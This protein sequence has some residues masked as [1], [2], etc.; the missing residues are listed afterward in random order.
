[1]PKNLWLLLG[2]GALFFYFREKVKEQGSL[3]GK[4]GPWKIN[5]NQVVDSVMPWI[6]VHP[7]A[8]EAIKTASKSFLSGVVGEDFS[9]AIDAKYR[10]IQ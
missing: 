8:K 7:L 10:R 9:D 6:N 1:M 5:P 4:I 2:L 3:K